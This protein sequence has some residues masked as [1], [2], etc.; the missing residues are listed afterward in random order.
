MVLGWSGV[1]FQIQDYAPLISPEALSGHN[2]SIEMPVEIKIEEKYER[3]GWPSIKRPDLKPPEGWSLELITAANRV[4]N[5]QLSPDGRRIAFIWDRED[6]SDVYVMSTEGGWP[7]RISMQRG[8]VAHWDDEIPQWSP[9]SRWLAFTMNDHVYVATAEGGLPRKVSGFTDKA[10]MLTWMPD[11]RELLVSVERDESLQL[12]LTDR[13]GGWP[14]PLVTLP[15]DVHDARPSPDGRSIVF[16][17]CPVDDPN[18]LDLRLLDVQSGQIHPLTDTPRQKDWFPRWSPD[19]KQIAFIS[20]RSGFNEAWLIRPDGEGMHQ[21]T[22]L[23]MDVSDLAWSPDERQ[24][25]GCVNRQGAFDLVLIDAASGEVTTL[26]KNEGIFSGPNWSPDG[27]FLTVEYEDPLQPPDLYRVSLPAG[28][29]TQLTFSNPPALKGNKLVM[30]ERVSYPGW[31]GMEI[32]ALLF[33]PLRSNGA[34]I[35]HPHGGPSSQYI[36]DWDILAQYFIAKGYTFLAPNYRGSTGYGVAFEHANYNDW[37]SGDMQ[38]CLYAAR[39]LH[40]LKWI[41]PKRIA[42]FGGSYGGYMTALCLS[43][44]P[45][46]L[47]AC[48][49]SKYGDA[50]LENSW[51]LCKRSLRIY[52]E[53]MLGNPGRNRQVYIDG[54]PIYQV[55]NIQKPVL[56]LHGLEDDVVPPEASEMWV[57]ALRRVGKTFEYKTYSGEPHGFLKRATQLDAYE[58]IERFLDWYLMP[59]PSLTRLPSARRRKEK[60]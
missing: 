57:E 11:S 46:Y 10:S 19:G 45:E 2:W 37:G 60:K 9:D 22:R 58:R 5:H 38:D 59:S 50:H 39:Y 40:T 32:P 23:G 26:R 34:A 8:P 1:I 31:K 53:M 15:G 20:Q 47:F 4:R 12:L 54:S 49:I 35:V 27:S 55:E 14:R 42:I 21:L 13:D 30:P 25:A 36:F 28:E 51:A 7:F 16:V 24:I 48:G 43:R 3:Y 52:S 56:I 41:D 6:L 18:R 29:M 33:R 44:D 17:F